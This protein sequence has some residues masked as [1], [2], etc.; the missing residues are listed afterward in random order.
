MPSAA[1]RK[2]CEPCTSRASSSA[3]DGVGLRVGQPAAP[4][5]DE[6]AQA[7]RGRERDPRAAPARVLERAR[8]QPVGLV[9]ALGEHQRDRAGDERVPARRRIGRHRAVRQPARREVG[10]LV[11]RAAGG[12]GVEREPGQPEAVEVGPRARCGG[13]GSA[14]SRGASSLRAAIEM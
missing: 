5:G 4:V 10:H 1:E 12:E 14:A 7:R 3:A 11:R 13:S 9:V 6:R 2:P 8:V